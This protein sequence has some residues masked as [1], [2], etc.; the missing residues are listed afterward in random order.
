MLLGHF[1]IEIAFLLVPWPR[2]FILQHLSH[3]AVKQRSY[4]L[5]LT[6]GIASM[7][8]LMVL[9]A[10]IWND[11]NSKLRS[12]PPRSLCTDTTNTE[13]AAD[14]FV[15]G[16]SFCLSEIT[17]RPLAHFPKHSKKLWGG[18]NWRSKKKNL[19]AKPKVL[20]IWEP[21]HILVLSQNTELI[22]PKKIPTF[23]ILHEK[24]CNES[25]YRDKNRLKS[26]KVA[27]KFKEHVLAWCS[28]VASKWF[29]QPLWDKEVWRT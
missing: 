23:H 29:F 19:W 26:K 13:T 20:G 24:E 8:L 3:T 7:S 28:F 16:G 22:L 21:F 4:T 9:I 14:I 12:S 2:D 5:P 6:Y 1:E 18:K 17:L 15:S 25:K 11:K 10:W 27:S